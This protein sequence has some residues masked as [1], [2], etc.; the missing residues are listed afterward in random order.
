MNILEKIGAIFNLLNPF[1]EDF[2]VY[3]LIDLLGELL[4]SLF[5]PSEERITA[6]TDTVSSKF[7]FIDTIKTSINSLKDTFNNMDSSVKL[8][9]STITSK[10]YNGKLT[11]IDMSW[12]APFKPYGDLVITG[13]VYLFFLWRVFVRIPSIIGTKEV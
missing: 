12:Y 11:I 7:G 10:Y 13:F 8:E 4:K 3:K 6:L 9:T 1:S 5:V 2:F